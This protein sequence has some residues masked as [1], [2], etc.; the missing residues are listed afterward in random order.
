M[1]SLAA[2]ARKKNTFIHPA[3]VQMSLGTDLSIRSYVIMFSQFQ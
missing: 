1:A 2:S 3:N